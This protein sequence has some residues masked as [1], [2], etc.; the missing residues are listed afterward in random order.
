[1]RSIM[2]V[3]LDN[4]AVSNTFSNPAPLGKGVC[5]CACYGL[6]GVANTNI[7]VPSSTAC[8]RAEAPAELADS[9]LGNQ[10]GLER[11]GHMI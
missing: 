3:K 9:Q 4:H 7:S 11:E 8:F 6:I 5:V 2:S 1:M 10:S